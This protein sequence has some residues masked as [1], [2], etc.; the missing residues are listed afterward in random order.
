MKA[1][2]RAQLKTMFIAGVVDCAQYKYSIS[3]KSKLKVW[4][5]C[6]KHL[7][8]LTYNCYPECI[9][10]DCNQCC[11]FNCIANSDLLIG[12]VDASWF[13][14]RSRQVDVSDYKDIYPLV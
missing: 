7:Q 13:I 11:N 8:K 12:V 1:R 3:K 6:H 10:K 5:P 4:L 2:M 14:I 9:N